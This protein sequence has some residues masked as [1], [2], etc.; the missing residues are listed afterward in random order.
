MFS[1]GRS[2]AGQHEIARA[3]AR[4][5]QCGP[6]YARMQNALAE[7]LADRGQPFIKSNLLA[8]ADQAGTFWGISVDR[9]ARRRFSCVICWFCEHF[10]EIND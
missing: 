8:L 1:Q 3:H 7:Y 2:L 10:P 9:A 4:I 5:Q 6:Q